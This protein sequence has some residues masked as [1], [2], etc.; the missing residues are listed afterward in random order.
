MTTVRVAPREF[1][2][3]LSTLTSNLPTRQHRNKLYHLAAIAIRPNGRFVFCSHLQGIRQR[4]AGEKKSAPYM[5][6]GIYRYNFG[7]RENA[8][9]VAPFFEQVHVRPIQ[10]FLP[11]ARTLR[12]LPVVR[13]SRTAER[14]PGLRMFGSLL[15]GVA[16]SP[17]VGPV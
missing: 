10:I 6:G 4:L 3:V 14:I 2:V 15:V 8:S 7:L 13:L 12:L 11:L 17:L 9:E 1:D 16:D 5:E